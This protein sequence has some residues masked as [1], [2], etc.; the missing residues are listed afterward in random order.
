MG[1]VIKPCR[2]CGSSERSPRSGRCVQCHRA[3]SRAWVDN[4]PEAA[5]KIVRRWYEKNKEKAI[6]K[7]A[8]WAENNKSASKATKKRWEDRNPRYLLFSGARA[9]AKERGVVFTIKLA[10]VQIP[11]VCPY[12]GIPLA[13]GKG[14]VSPGSPSLDRIDSTKGYEPGNVEVISFRANCIKSSYSAQELK[15][16]ADRLWRITNKKAA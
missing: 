12:L 16:V 2:K 7:A 9:R 4:N 5:K 15:Q 8:T 1:G 11:G 13:R 10:D 14:K 6:A 3:G